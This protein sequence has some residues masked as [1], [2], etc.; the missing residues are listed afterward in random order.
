MSLFPFANRSC[1]LCL[2][3]LQK[4]IVTPSH[5]P[6]ISGRVLDLTEAPIRDWVRVFNQGR[7][8]DD[9][10]T[11]QELA[12]LLKKHVLRPENLLVG[13]DGAVP[14]S[15]VSLFHDRPRST[16][17][18]GDFVLAPGHDGKGLA[19]VDTILECARKKG[20]SRVVAWMRSGDTKASDTLG[21]FLFDLRQI[22][23]HMSLLLEN[24]FVKSKKSSSVEV[25]SYSPRLGDLLHEGYLS[26]TEIRDITSKDWR[27]CS[28]V[29]LPSEDS[30]VVGFCSKRSPRH[31][32]LLLDSPSP[33]SP[34]QPTVPK[35]ALLDVLQSM[36]SRGVYFVVSE[37]S[38]DRDTRTVFESVGFSANRT[39]YQLVFEIA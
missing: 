3:Y 23:V 24:P 19:I 10:L 25:G 7:S 1:G 12:R 37:I 26:I 11:E 30:Y 35:V 31:G 32:M 29:P 36:H 34:F 21:M 18:I 38:A 6:T 8:L 17:G 4:E 20:Y 39:L 28:V 9:P 14:T 15:C 2:G 27:L 13:Y 5:V 33:T 16:V 22:R